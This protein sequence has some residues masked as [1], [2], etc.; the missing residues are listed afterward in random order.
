MWHA[1]FEGSKV[2]NIGLS[3]TPINILFALIFKVFLP[4]PHPNNKNHSLI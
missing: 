2:L 3:S 4:L 1:D